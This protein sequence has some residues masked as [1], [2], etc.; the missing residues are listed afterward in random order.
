MKEQMPECAIIPAI[1][2]KLH[3]EIFSASGFLKHDIWRPDD[4]GSY[5]EFTDYVRYDVSVR[6]WSNP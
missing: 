6:S 3:K 1:L 4:F 2:G 5:E